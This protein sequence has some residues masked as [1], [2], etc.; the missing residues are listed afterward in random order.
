MSE[1]AV[2]HEVDLIRK[3]GDHFPVVSRLCWVRGSVRAARQG[4]VFD[5]RK[6][7][8]E[9]VCDKFRAQIASLELPVWEKNMNDHLLELNASVLDAA[10]ERFKKDPVRPR[11]TYIQDNTFWLIRVRRAIQRALRKVRHR[12]GAD[13]YVNRLFYLAQDLRKGTRHTKGWEVGA[14]G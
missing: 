6:L 2:L 4:A 10:N 7:Q 5:A 12:G 1:V 13:R 9:T 3:Q 14:F 11:K 8:G